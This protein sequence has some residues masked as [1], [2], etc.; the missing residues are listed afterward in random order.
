MVLKS[1]PKSLQ[2]LAKPRD[3]FFKDHW[4]FVQ[5]CKDRVCGYVRFAPKCT[6]PC[7]AVFPEYS[8]RNFGVPEIDGT[9]KI[10]KS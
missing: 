7:A 8:E 2:K 6:G 10:T 3:A 5:F 1:Q 9:V 4:G